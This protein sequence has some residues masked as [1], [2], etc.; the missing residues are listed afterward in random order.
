MFHTKIHHNN[1]LKF[2]RENY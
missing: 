2:Q 1:S